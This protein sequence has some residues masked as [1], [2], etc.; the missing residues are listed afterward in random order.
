MVTGGGTS[1]H[2][3]PAITIAS[4]LMKR[5]NRGE[6]SCRIIF[7]GRAGG[8]EG[9]LVPAAGFDFRDVPAK[10]LPLRPSP[11]IFPAAASVNK[12][13]KICMDLIREFKPMAVISTGGFSGVPLLYAARSLNVPIIIHEANAFP[14]R[15]NKMM[16]KKAALVMTGFPNQEKD[17]PKAGKVLFTGNPVRDIMFGNN[18]TESRIKLGIAPDEKFVFAMGGSLGAVTISDFII[19]AAKEMPGVRFV[20][21]AGK[22]HADEWNN[23]TKDINNLTVLSYIDEPNVYMSAA[24]VSILRAGAVTCAELG[25][26]GGCGILIP[27][28]HAAF[29]HQTYNA[30]CIAKEGGCLVMK[31]S[32]VAEGKL[33]PVFKEL[34]G[35]REKQMSLRR[36]VS[37]MA[38]PDTTERI[39]DAIDEVIRGNMIK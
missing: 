31:D 37:K 26:V 17:F 24:D 32:D 35:D 7:T 23:V 21:S 1:G 22:Q 10:P 20:L 9:D 12:G 8:L 38:M 6:D 14:G 18:M 34:L 5:Y 3:N 16:G 29:D 15:A 30:E 36:N 27:Y 28:P 39:V 19:K 2:I 11:K 25:A 33:M 13:R 4:A